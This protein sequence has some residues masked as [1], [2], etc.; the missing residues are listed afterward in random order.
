MTVNER[1]IDDLIV[2][3]EVAE[4]VVIETIIERFFDNEQVAYIHLHFAR[5]G[6][7]AARVDRA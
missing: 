6:C 5:R 2:E 1:N 7:Y 4:G 3:A